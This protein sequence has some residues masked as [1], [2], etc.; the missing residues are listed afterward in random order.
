MRRT[1]PPPLPK[2]AT[3]GAFVRLSDNGIAVEQNAHSA[4]VRPISHCD[5][6]QPGQWFVSPLL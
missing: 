2:P 3:G 4:V 1:L 6:P 5:R